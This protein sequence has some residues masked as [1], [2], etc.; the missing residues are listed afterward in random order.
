MKKFSPKL[1]Y[2]ITLM[3]LQSVFIFFIIFYLSMKIK[4]FNTIISI[5]SFII[6]IKLLLGKKNINFKLLWSFLLLSF[7]ELSLVLWILSVITNDNKKYYCELKN[8]EGSKNNC[9]IYKYLSNIS[10]CYMY[11]NTVIQHFPYGEIFFSDYINE[12]KK[13]KKSI[14]IEYFIIGNGAMWEQIVEILKKK[15]SEGVEVKIIR[16]GLGTVNFF[17]KKYFNELK[18][19]GIESQTFNEFTPLLTTLFKCR[20]HRKITVIDNFTAYTGGLNL[21]DE[22]INSVRVYGYWKDYA[23]KI[24]G[25]AVNEFSR[26]FFESWNFCKKSRVYP[27]IEFQ[28]SEINLSGEYIIPFGDIPNKSNPVGKNA[29]M[30]IL[31][32]ARDYVYIMTPYLVIDDEIRNLLTLKAYSGVD[33]RIITPHIADKKYVH[34]VTRS[35]YHQLIES[36][37][38]IYEYKNGFI[39]AKSVIS[40]DDYGIAGTVN[41]DFRSFHML[42]ENSIFMY[43]TKTLYQLKSD[44]LNT[45]ENCIEITDEFFQNKSLLSRITCG[46]LRFFSAMM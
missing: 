27:S 19:Y 36:G 6:C 44:Y 30:N 34:A 9:T 23:F 40:D 38:R 14:L 39:H 31:S 35:N 43:K 17:S 24:R 2:T 10:G 25:D 29:Y 20:D 33:I 45:I 26:I 21:S 5:I 42:F 37:V 16:D 7:P 32:N 11:E 4:Y 13:A 12:L 3:I 8:F 1:I 18:K 15:A 22:Y 46:V 28:R 41:F